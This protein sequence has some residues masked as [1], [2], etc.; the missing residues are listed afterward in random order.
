MKITMALVMVGG[1]GSLQKANACMNGWMDGRMGQPRYEK[2]LHRQQCKNSCF[3]SSFQP[4]VLIKKLP[5]FF[6]ASL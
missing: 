1:D 3:W 4:L 2:C 5:L 6:V